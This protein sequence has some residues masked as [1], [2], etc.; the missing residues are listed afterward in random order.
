MTRAAAVECGRTWPSGSDAR[1]TG[2]QPGV[3]CGERP[4]YPRDGS[5]S[6]E[7]DEH[8]RNRVAWLVA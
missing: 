3:V 4:L 8:V 6:G 2:I 1:S 5:S 7:F